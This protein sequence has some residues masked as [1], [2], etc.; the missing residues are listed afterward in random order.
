MVFLGG[1]GENHS[2]RPYFFLRGICYAQT[3][4]AGEIGRQE[5]N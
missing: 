5:L 4:A 1:V 3:V 2:Y